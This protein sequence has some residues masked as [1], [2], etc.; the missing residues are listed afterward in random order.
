MRSLVETLILA[1]LASPAEPNKFSTR[2]V[3]SLVAATRHTPKT[4]YLRGVK[5]VKAKRAALEGIHTLPK[6]V[7]EK[8][9]RQTV[10][11]DQPRS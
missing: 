11:E 5:A 1:T 7:Y 6:S 8:L 2:Q 4:T 9:S 3:A 10:E